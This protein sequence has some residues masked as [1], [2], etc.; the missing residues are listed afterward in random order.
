MWAINLFSLLYL[1][2]LPTLPHVHVS[3]FLT[4]VVEAGGFEAERYNLVPHLISI[5]MRFV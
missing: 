4:Q 1:S 3:C 5:Y 2:P